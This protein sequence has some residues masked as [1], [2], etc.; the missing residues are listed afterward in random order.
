MLSFLRFEKYSGSGNDFLVFDTSD[1]RFPIEDPAFVMRLCHRHE[2]IGADGL[3]L[4]TPQGANCSRLVILNADG[5]RAPMCGNGLCCIVEWMFRH[6]HAGPTY[7]VLTDRGEMLGT[8]L[9]D[10]RIRV[11]M[12]PIT[13][14][15]WG[16]LLALGGHEY[17]V[18]HLNT[19]VPH[20]VLFVE[21]LQEVD[22]AH[23]GQALR[24]HP[25]FAPEGANVDF[26]QV[27]STGKIAVRT[28]ERGVE[29]ETQSCGTGMAAAAVAACHLFGTTQPVEVASQGG[30]GIWVSFPEDFSNLSLSAKANFVFEG[31]LPFGDYPLDSNG[32]NTENELLATTSMLQE[33]R[34]S[35]QL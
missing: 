10:G 9:S 29:G 12:G 30:D 25:Y 16:V 32:I 7:R 15:Q 17:E 34:P 13:E 18:H 4:V 2:G 26:V 5:S 33:R 24:R 27:S 35:V 20:I 6:G 11:E 14:V 1:L 31:T 8:R 23:L 19:G 22:V 28:Y 21:D 3:L